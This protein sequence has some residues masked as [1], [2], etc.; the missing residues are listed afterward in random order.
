MINNIHQ[1]TEKYNDELHHLESFIKCPYKLYFQHILAFKEGQIRWRQV[2]QVHN[3]VVQ[4]Y[5]QLPGEK[6]TKLAIL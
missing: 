1:I 2:V 3:W 4:A 5:H 6:Q